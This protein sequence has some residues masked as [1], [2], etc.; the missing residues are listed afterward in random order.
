MFIK[1]ERERILKLRHD[2]VMVIETLLFECHI[3]RHVRIPILVLAR[4]AL[5][6]QVHSSDCGILPAVTE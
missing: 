3:P 1:G 2:A 6:V 4:E 5:A